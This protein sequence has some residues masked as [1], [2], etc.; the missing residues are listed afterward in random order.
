MEE[1]IYGPFLEI[2]KSVKGYPDYD[3]S[4]YGRV[5]SFKRNSEKILK[6]GL[7]GGNGIV[8]LYKFVVLSNNNITKH[9]SIHQLVGQYI[10]NPRNLKYIN[11]KDGDPSNNFHLNL[12]WVSN[13]ENQCHS[14]K[15]RKTTSQYI[16]VTW[17]KRDKTWQSQIMIN[18]KTIYLGRFT[19]EL[20]AYQARCDYELNNNIINKYLQ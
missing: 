16:G 9:H 13:M 7:R 20:E 14:Y 19:N 5:K 12:E 3:I 4:S 11:H 2:W 1:L 15:T 8:K 10:S 6:P 17:F 18:G